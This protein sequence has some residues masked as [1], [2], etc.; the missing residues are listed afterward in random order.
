MANLQ[1]AH[2]ILSQLTAGRENTIKVISWGAR[3]YV[4]DKNFLMFTVSG[5]LHKGQVKVIYVEGLDLYTVE[6]YKTRAIEPCK[7]IEMVYFDELTEK[8]DEFVEKQ[9]NYS[10]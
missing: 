10:F 9:S 6:F 5:R 1:I 3:N 2:T 4:G 8:I 7:V